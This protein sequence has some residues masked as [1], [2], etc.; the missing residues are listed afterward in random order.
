MKNNGIFVMV[1]LNAIFIYIIQNYFKSDQQIRLIYEELYFKPFSGLI[2]VTMF[3]FIIM[4]IYYSVITIGIQSLSTKESIQ[5]TN[6][7]QLNF[8]FFSG[9]FLTYEIDQI[10]KSFVF[11]IS[12]CSVYHLL[13][14]LGNQKFQ[15]FQNE[16]G[17]QSEKHRLLFF[18]L[19]NIISLI[20]MIIVIDDILIEQS[21]VFKSELF[22][23]LIKNIYVL[24]KL[25][26]FFYLKPE[27]MNRAWKMKFILSF[28]IFQELLVMNLIYHHTKNYKMIFQ[29]ILMIRFCLIIFF[30]AQELLNFLRTIFAWIIV[31]AQKQ[32]KWKKY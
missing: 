15:K 8:V 16:S 29:K 2:L 11:Y 12:F 19:F 27:Q 1:F 5:L 10:P 14:F 21:I 26:N 9:V 22:F 13:Y 28:E 32:R 3:V 31:V 6:Q 17:K 25:L 18:L 4:S 24:F 23:I 30:Q 7:V 20:L